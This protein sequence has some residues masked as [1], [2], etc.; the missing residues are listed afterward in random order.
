MTGE[1][2]GF[3]FLFTIHWANDMS[4]VLTGHMCRHD[5]RVVDHPTFFCLPPLLGLVSK[6]HETMWHFW[7]LATKSC[8]QEPL[9]CNSETKRKHGTVGLAAYGTRRTPNS[10]LGNYLDWMTVYK[11]VH[12]STTLWTP[13]IYIHHLSSWEHMWGLVS[14]PNGDPGS[15]PPYNKKVCVTLCYHL[16]SWERKPITQIPMR[17]ISKTYSRHI[18][19]TFKTDSKLVIQQLVPV[20]MTICATCRACWTTG[21]WSTCVWVWLLNHSIQRYT[22]VLRCF[23]L[24]SE[25]NW[26]ISNA[27]VQ[28]SHTTPHYNGNTSSARR[29]CRN[30]FRHWNLRIA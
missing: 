14:K 10:V 19:S 16:F 30:W 17:N 12:L 21:P 20:W 1:K 5:L 9:L 8:V 25:R 11:Q 23:P 24:K 22:K 28:P 29:I 7:S 15:K 2:W 18:H 3:S 26:K 27:R 4:M 6:W 13:C